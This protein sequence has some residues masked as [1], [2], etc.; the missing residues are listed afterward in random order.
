MSSREK[1]LS[2]IRRHRPP[3][4]A[5]PSLDQD[6]ITYPDP[7][8]QFSEMLAAVGGRCVVVKDVGEI[9][10]VLSD[11]PAY[12]AAD[13]VLSRVPGVARSDV[14]L[15]AIADPHELADLDFAVLPAEFAVA[16]NAAV[17]V[18]DAALRHRV[19]LFIAQHLA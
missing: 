13:T 12:V 14:D 11:L 3:P 2:A 6:W 15:D 17:W 8:T 4:V 16:E 19:V 9:D 1:I 18:T 5:L 10:G 7:R